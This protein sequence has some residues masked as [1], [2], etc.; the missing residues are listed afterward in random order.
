M[1]KLLMKVHDVLPLLLC[2][3]IGS[4]VTM[5]TSA[6]P[7]VEVTRYRVVALSTNFILPFA[8]FNFTEVDNKQTVGNLSLFKSVGAGF[9]LNYGRMS[10]TVEK[11]SQNEDLD[12]KFYNAIGL[13]LGVLFSADLSTDQ[14]TNVFAPTIGVSLMD[15]AV[16]WGYELGTHRDGETGHFIT[17][18]YDIPLQK[19]SSKG[20]WPLWKKKLEDDQL[21]IR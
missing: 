19:L 20:T 13:N 14:P 17:V 1:N 2:T 9:T 16:G 4:G 18:S 3:S 6:Q 10:T 11:D 5:R 15:F 21:M 8:R 12:R 7:E